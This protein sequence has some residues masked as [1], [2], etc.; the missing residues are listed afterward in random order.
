[1]PRRCLNGVFPTGVGGVILTREALEKA[2]EAG[3]GGKKKEEKEKH[4]CCLCLMRSDCLC[5]HVGLFAEL[6]AGVSWIS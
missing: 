6:L 1:M 3:M 5:G 2:D 4:H